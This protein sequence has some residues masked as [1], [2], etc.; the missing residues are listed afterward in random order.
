MTPASAPYILRLGRVTGPDFVAAFETDGVVRKA[1]PILSFML[2]WSDDKV[3]EHVAAKG[4]KA[5]L[6]TA[7]VGPPPIVQHEESFEV[8]KGG[9]RA[10]FYFDDIAGRR[11][12][13]GCR[14]RPRTAAQEW[15]TA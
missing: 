15:M 3:R 12:I 11:A 14:A 6:V 13:S 1:A 2:G 7:E 10:F 8:V 5:S 4:W 9:L